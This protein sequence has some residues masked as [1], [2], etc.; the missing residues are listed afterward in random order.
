[1]LAD[2]MGLGKTVQTLAHILTE[3]EAGRLTSPALVIA[4]TSLMA[5]WFDEAARFAPSLKVLL[6]QGK[7]RMDLF[8]QIDDADIVLTTYALLPRDEE[9]LR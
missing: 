6:L 5:N 7:E 3:K 2:D 8:D 9:K 4:P 1:I